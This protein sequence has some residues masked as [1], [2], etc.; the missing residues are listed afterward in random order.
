LKRLKI[1]R[2]ILPFQLSA[3][4]ISDLPISALPNQ[5]EFRVVGAEDGL[6][7]GCFEPVAEDGAVDAAE[8]DVVFDVAFVQV[9]E[10]GVGAV[11]AAFDGRAREEEAGGFAVVGTDA[12]VFRDAAAKLGE[13]HEDDAFVISLFLEVGEEGF[14]SAVELP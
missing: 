6:E 1:E 5:P 7:L 11:K 9:G 3:F 10:A 12:G 4:P 14:E 13:G 2:V 8:I